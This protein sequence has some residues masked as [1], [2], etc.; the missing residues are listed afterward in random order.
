[1]F[2]DSGSVWALKRPLMSLT[3]KMKKGDFWLKPAV[4]EHRYA[5]VLEDQRILNFEVC[6]VI[7]IYDV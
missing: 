1:M 4:A 6:L 3:S 2:V 7:I 5:D